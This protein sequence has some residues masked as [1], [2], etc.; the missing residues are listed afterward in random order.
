MQG[1]P[2]GERKAYEG[3]EEKSDED[4]TPAIPKCVR[5]KHEDNWGLRMLVG[6]LKQA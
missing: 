1:V 2:K 4:R 3:Y 6:M 5:P